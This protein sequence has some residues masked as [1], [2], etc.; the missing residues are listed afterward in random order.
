MDGR[1]NIADST[2]IL[3]ALFKNDPVNYPIKCQDSADAN[4]DGKI[5]LADAIYLNSYLFNKGP[6]PKMP[7]PTP[8]IDPSADGLGCG[9]G[10]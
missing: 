4:D 6:K 8:G 5:D 7:F 10:L 1:A 3:N 2:Y 9:K